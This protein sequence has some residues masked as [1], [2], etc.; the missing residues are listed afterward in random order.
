LSAGDEEVSGGVAQNLTNLSYQIS[1]KE[2]REQPNLS[3]AVAEESRGIASH[4]RTQPIH[5]IAIQ[6]GQV[7]MTI[8]PAS[9]KKPR[10]TISPSSIVSPA[11]TISVAK[12]KANLSSV[13]TGVE[14]KKTAV[15]ILRRGVPV[16]QI[17]PIADPQPT[18]GYGW[19]RGTV[20]EL[21]DI[22][23]PTGVE[24]TAGDE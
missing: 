16:A 20:Q 13:L 21:G 1:T 8:M 22:V 19:M 14:K 12:A 5:P 6:Y 15:T 7:E 23:G 18:S 4:F 3:A 2:K 17:I 10:P 24:W 9:T 11:K